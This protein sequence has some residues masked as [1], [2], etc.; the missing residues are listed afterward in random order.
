[1]PTN[2]PISKRQWRKFLQR[3]RSE[4]DYF[5]LL[6]F[7]S[8]SGV[9]FKNYK[10]PRRW[11]PASNLKITTADWESAWPL[12]W[13]QIESGQLEVLKESPSGDVL[14]GE[15]VLGGKPIQI[16]VKRPY[17]RY[18]YR[19]LNEVGRG[20]RAWRAWRKAWNMVVRDIPTA[21]PL[22]MMQKRTL[23]YIT[24]AVFVQERVA[25][26]TLGTVDLNSMDAE[27]RDMLFRRTGRILRQIEWFGM[28]HFDAKASN[29]I[30]QEDPK[31]GPR[32]VLIDVDGIRNR[33]WAALGID[34]LLRS[35]R[36]H[37]QYT[38][39]DSLSLCRGYAPYSRTLVEEK[40]DAD[41]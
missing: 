28:S 2:N 19:Y 39:A 1:M 30:V 23:G 24:D 8:W 38:A 6:K 7:D 29:W 18:W 40:E 37:P 33:R 26:A 31:L 4:N 35:M 34:R 27:A 9:C 21:W 22:M 14:A 17:K 15:V 32:P 25:G 20:S 12:L 11:A 10:Y 13:R 3:T 5:G 41:K 36:E 16:I